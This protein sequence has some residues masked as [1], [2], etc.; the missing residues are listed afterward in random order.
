[1]I[2]KKRCSGLPAVPAQIDRNRNTDGSEFVRNWDETSSTR[3][4]GQWHSLKI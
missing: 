1:M 3:P 2:H 4:E